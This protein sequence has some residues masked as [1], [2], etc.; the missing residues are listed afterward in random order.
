MGRIAERVLYVWSGPMTRRHHG[1]SAGRSVAIHRSWQHASGQL[2]SRLRRK[3][4]AFLLGVRNLGGGESVWLLPVDLSHG[5][6]V[7][8]DASQ[9]ARNHFMSRSHDGQSVAFLPDRLDVGRGGPVGMC[10]A[11]LSGGGGL[12]AD[13]HRQ[14]THLGVRHRHARIQ[15][16]RVRRWRCLGGSQHELVQ[17]ESR[18]TLSFRSDC[19]LQGKR[20]A[21][22]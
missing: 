8:E 12:A 1:L 18:G 9:P 16:A 4:D 14:P 15:N 22:N 2:S 11:Q 13:S 5:G 21:D 10:G 3:G 20:L 7:A 6:R 17:W 19:V